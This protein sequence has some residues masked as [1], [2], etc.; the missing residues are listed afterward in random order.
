[1]AGDDVVGAVDDTIAQPAQC[2]FIAAAEKHRCLRVAIHARRRTST[3][4]DRW[5]LLLVLP[6]LLV[7]AVLLRVWGPHPRLPHPLLRYRRRLRRR[8]RL[9]L[10]RRKWRARR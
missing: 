1:M 6:L 7:A 8:L 4:H 5:L 3:F 10:W 2:C 9:R